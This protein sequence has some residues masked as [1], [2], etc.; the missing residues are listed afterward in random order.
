MEKLGRRLRGICHQLGIKQDP[1]AQ[2]YIP[3]ASAFRFY[4]KQILE[5]YF[6]QSQ[7]LRRDPRNK[8]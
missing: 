4:V 6:I 5:E 2:I 8:A 3:A 7:C 1:Q